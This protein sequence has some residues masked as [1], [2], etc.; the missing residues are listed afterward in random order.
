MKYYV[1]TGRLVLNGVKFFIEAAN[2]EEARRMA[3]RGEYEDYDVIGAE[4]VDWTISS[5]VRPIDS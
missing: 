5:A 2:E 4:A 1:C 3:E